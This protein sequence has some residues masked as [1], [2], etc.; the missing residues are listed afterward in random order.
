MRGPQLSKNW[1]VPVLCGS[2]ATE[3]TF[4]CEGLISRSTG[5]PVFL[6]RIVKS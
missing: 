5:M 3:R 4:R 2:G 6:N 1:F